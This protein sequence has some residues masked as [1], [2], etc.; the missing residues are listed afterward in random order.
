VSAAVNARPPRVVDNLRAALAAALAADPT[1]YLLGEDVVDPYGGAFK[2]TCGLSTRFPQ[3]VIG[4][5]ISEG[6]LVGVANGL[7]LAGDKAIVEIMFADFVTLAFDQIVNVAAKAVTMFGRTASVPLIVRCPTGGG[8]GYGPTHSQSLQKHFI[9]VPELSVHELSAFHDTVDVLAGLLDA[10]R[11]AIL[12][13]DKALYGMPVHT[14]GTVDELFGYD[15]TGPAPGV[16]RVH[17]DGPTAPTDCVLITPGG[18]AGRA[19]TAMRRLLL[20]D[21][22]VC[23]LLVPSRLYPLDL[24]P[25]LPS[26]ARTRQVCIVEESTAGGTWGAELAHRVQTAAWDTLEGPVRLVHSADS[27]IPSAKHLERQVLVG[28]DAI[29]RAVRDAVERRGVRR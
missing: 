1:L 22:I 11:P 13:E 7:A 4:T 5:P 19:L 21:E 8:R 18:V 10:G 15:L 2:V 25:M 26:L 16:A 20:E 12:F 17:A 27:V 3:Q 24:A 14:G 28:P 6:A 23:Q 9:G 29:R